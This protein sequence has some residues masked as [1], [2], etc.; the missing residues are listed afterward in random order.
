MTR[1]HLAAHF[2]DL[3]SSA[4]HA[5]NLRQA[6]HLERKA[7]Q[8]FASAD[9]QEAVNDSVTRVVELYEREAE[10][11]LAGPNGSAMA[12]GLFI[13]KAI[14]TLRSLPRKYRIARGL[15][16]HLANLRQQ[17]EENRE[18]TLEG[19]MRI[20]TDE[21]D[22]TDAIADT[23]RRLSGHSRFDALVYLAAS[24]PLS[25]PDKERAQAEELAKGSLRHLFGGAT[26]AADGRK[27]A[28][29]EGGLA[30]PDAAIWSDVVRSAGMKRGIVATAFII[31]GLDVITFEHRYDQPYLHRL[32]LES[33]LVP[34]GHEDLWARGLR[35]GLNG[36]FPSAISVL[37]PQIEHSLRRVL[38][39]HGV[40]TLVVDGSTGV[41]SEK[42]LGALLAMP[43]AADALGAELHFELKALLIE[44]QGDNLRHDTAHGLLHDAQAWSAGAIYAWWLCLRMV[45]VPLWNMRRAA[46]EGEPP[47][48]PPAATD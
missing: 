35:H 29:T 3:A 33:P 45:M 38:K 34:S 20:Q 13:E 31:P 6:R 46:D 2:A 18:D 40:Y 9:E 8:W 4:N 43:E 22:L 16:S 37:V 39:N 26:Y 7:Q 30:E 19:M 44:Q 48:E 32:C 14:S 25:D 24:W 5:A 17:L 47:M 12:A 23:R 1:R 36:D 41:E 15:E 27:V 28:S 21:V 10:Q 11:R 42:G